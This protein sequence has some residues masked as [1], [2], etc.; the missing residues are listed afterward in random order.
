MVI[1][2]E[3]LPGAGK[4]TAAGLVAERLGALALR[5]TT[6]DHPFLQ[7]VYDD[8][9]RDDLTVEL[10]FLIV[11]ANP[12][13]RIDRSRLTICDF[14]P[15][16][17]VL[18]A[19]EM[20]VAADLDLFRTVY[21]RVYEAHPL[22]EAVVYIRASPELCFERI[23]RRIT[24]DPARA[25][26]AGMT[27]DRLRRMQSR[28]ESGIGRLGEDVLTVDADAQLGPLDQATVIVEALGRRYGE[29]FV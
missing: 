10:S 28:Y 16:K 8:G 18:F 9:D 4:T 3:G 15:A 20:L 13:R 19:E 22:P 21:D 11:H 2:L 5:E 7:Q 14:S 27:V 23:R 12:F 29:L 17:D 25:F 6:G 26:E 1:A 24:L